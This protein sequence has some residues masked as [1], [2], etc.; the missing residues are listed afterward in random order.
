MSVMCDNHIP[1]SQYQTVMYLTNSDINTGY[2]TL[3]IT[4]HKVNVK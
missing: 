4:H 1:D 2:T 3:T